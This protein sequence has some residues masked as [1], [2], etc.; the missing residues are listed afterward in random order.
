MIE[1]E[2]K[3]MDTNTRTPILSD[4]EIESIAEQLLMDYKPALLQ[5]PGK[6]NALH[7]IESYL[8]A[9]VD[10]QDI[11]YP[12]GKAAILGA[13]AFIESYIRVFDREKLRTVK[14]KVH[15]RTVVL[16]NSIMKS[17]KEG[18]QLFTALHEGGH[19]YLHPSVYGRPPE[20]L[21]L[22]HPEA[23]ELSQVVCCRRETIDG[24]GCR[25]DSRNWTDEDFREHQANVFA[26]S[27]AMP[28]KTFVPLVQQFYKDEDL[29]TDRLYAGNAT[30]EYFVVPRL[31]WLL[32]STFGVSKSAAMV[33]LKKYDLYVELP[34]KKPNPPAYPY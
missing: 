13:T 31:L 5:K 23:N 33:Q 6:I 15:R 3:R 28:R 18:L 34:K 4:I 7:F 8:G 2:C 20:Q 17:G 19:L 16:D 12:Q 21:M 32:C 25:R 30:M 22:F 1:F 29:V 10:Y 24:Y 9:E 27:I 14:K 11:Y 26:A